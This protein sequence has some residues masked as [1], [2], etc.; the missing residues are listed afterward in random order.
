M[1]INARNVNRFIRCAFG[2]MRVPAAGRYNCHG[3]SNGGGG[4][5]PTET[6]SHRPIVASVGRRGG[7]SSFKNYIDLPDERSNDLS[8]LFIPTDDFESD[9]ELMADAGC[10]S[11]GM[12]AG[13]RRPIYHAGS[14]ADCIWDF[15][16]TPI[17][18]NELLDNSPGIMRGRVDLYPMRSFM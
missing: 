2:E 11:M 7:G 14:T 3:F 15:P 9:D 4:I 12:G 1:E 17:L 5:D 16:D 8:K 10:T 18:P 13:V 6:D